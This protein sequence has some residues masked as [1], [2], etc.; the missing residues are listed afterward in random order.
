MIYP[1][2]LYIIFY[3][4]RMRCSWNLQGADSFAAEIYLEVQ[5]IDELALAAIERAGSIARC[6]YYDP[7]SIAVLSDPQKY[8]ITTSQFYALQSDNSWW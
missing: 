1:E 8:V 2:Y 6:R 4:W 5:W 7:K 3:V